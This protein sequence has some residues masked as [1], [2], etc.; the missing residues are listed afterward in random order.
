VAR[1]PPPALA[2]SD[3]SELQTAREGAVAASLPLGRVLIAGGL[4]G[5]NFLQSTE[6]M[7]P[8]PPSASISTPVPAG[9]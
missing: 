4:D 5:G 1:K 9:T 2:A 6:L 8:G 7:V 3:S